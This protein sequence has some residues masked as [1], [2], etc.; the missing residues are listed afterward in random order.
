VVWTIVEN[1]IFLRNEG[2][3]GN[4]LTRMTLSVRMEEEK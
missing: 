1:E 4:I 3:E 2:T